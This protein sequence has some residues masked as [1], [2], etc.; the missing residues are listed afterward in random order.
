MFFWIKVF[1]FLRA[2]RVEPN[3]TRRRTAFLEW[4][5]L[6]LWKYFIKFYSL[7]FHSSFLSIQYF[8]YKNFFSYK[9]YRQL[10]M[11]R[12]LEFHECPAW[13]MRP[14]L[15]WVKMLKISHLESSGKFFESLILE[16]PRLLRF[17]TSLSIS[18]SH[19]L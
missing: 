10:W 9:I 6:N 12:A 1:C 19:F 18:L 17:W 11:S 4:L 14:M 5:K 16:A 2:T 8:F 13:I 7:I 3:Q 15:L